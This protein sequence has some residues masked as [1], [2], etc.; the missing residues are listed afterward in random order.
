MLEGLPEIIPECELAALPRMQG[1]K[2]IHVAKFE[3]SPIPLS[4]LWLKYR[5]VNPRSGFVA[6]NVFRDTPRRRWPALFAQSEA[7]CEA[8]GAVV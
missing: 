6:V 5:I 2:G 7:R 4:R 8:P 3:V 1:A